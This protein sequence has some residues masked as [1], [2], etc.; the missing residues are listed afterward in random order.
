VSGVTFFEREKKMSET[1]QAR[2]TDSKRNTH[3]ET[4]Q[5]G[6]QG[7]K[8]ERGPVWEEICK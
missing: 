8:K 4:I 6:T 5:E 1:R 3:T 2:A 7:R